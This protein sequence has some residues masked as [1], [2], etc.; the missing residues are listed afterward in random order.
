MTAPHYPDPAREARLMELLR[1]AN[2]VPDLTTLRATEEYEP[3]QQLLADILERDGRRGVRVPTTRR[4]RRRRWIAVLLVIAISAGIAAGWLLTRKTDV[5]LGVLCFDRPSLERDGTTKR[6][7][8]A[9]SGTAVQSCA[10][11]WTNGDLG[12]SGPPALVACVLPNGTAGVFPGTS[13]DLC[14]TLGLSPLDPNQRLDEEPIA[15][16]KEA[17]VDYLSTCRTIEDGVRYAREQ[18]E[19]LG[20]RGWR[21]E[22]RRELTEQAPCAGFATDVEKKLVL[23]VP[24]P[25]RKQ[26]APTT[27]GS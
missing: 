6:A 9:P 17:V 3:A 2:P 7:V 13:G 1:R 22:S 24:S 18:L 21:V 25:P 20:V 11:E 19:A 8:V 15:K 5:P 12:T 16:L 14:R 10:R 23:I 27:T 4:Q 26:S